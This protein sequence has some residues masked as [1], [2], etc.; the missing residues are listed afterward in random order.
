MN[1]YVFLEEMGR[2]VG[3]WGKDIVRGGYSRSDARRGT[4]SRGGRFMAGKGRGARGKK[5]V[6][7]LQLEARD[8]EMEL[9][10]L[11]M[12]RRKLNQSI[13]DSRKRTALLTIDFKFHT[14]TDL[15]TPSSATQHTPA[16]L[17][18]HRNDMD[19]SL[20]ALVQKHVATTQK[21]LP[22]WVE[23]RVLPDTDDPDSF[24]PPL[25]VMAAPRDTLPNLG[26]V[27]QENHPVYYRFDA[28]KP[29]STLLKGTRF[30]EFPTI[31]VYEEFRGTVID[32]G[33]MTRIGDEGLAMK[34]RKLTPRAGKQAINDLVGEY[35]SEEEEQGDGQNVLS[36]LGN[37][38]D[39]EEVSEAVDDDMSSLGGDGASGDEE[40]SGDGVDVDP[41]TLLELVR[42]ARTHGQWLQDEE[43][44]L[45]EGECG[46]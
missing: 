11:G 9:L 39:G 29:L 37:Y 41:A 8:I 4:R 1:D 14:P 23:S 45:S 27:S 34:R 30:V 12:E 10:P 21:N 16:R 24:T 40:G 32:A 43:E 46:E 35:G 36:V 3:D 33:V 28:T 5:D 44:E 13:W 17:I 19:T 26:F 20:L 15:C 42:E 38:T 6:L 31:E 18:T 2:K 7:K 25:F 22:P